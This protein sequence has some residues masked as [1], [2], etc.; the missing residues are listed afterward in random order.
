MS[1][2]TSP[3]LSPRPSYSCD[4]LYKLSQKS[5][6]PN[7]AANKE[8]SKMLTNAVDLF[9]KLAQEPEE[10]PEEPKETPRTTLP[11]IFNKFSSTAPRQSSPRPNEKN[12]IQKIITSSS[13]CS[14]L[15][16]LS[17]RFMPISREASK[18]N[19][20]GWLPRLE[21][22]PV[23]L[24]NEE[25]VMLATVVD[26]MTML[27]QPDKEEAKEPTLLPLD[28]VNTASS[29]QQQQPPPPVVA[30]PP[31]TDEKQQV[32]SCLSSI[33]IGFYWYISMYKSTFPLLYANLA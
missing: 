12:A 29:I 10:K 16:K 9:T 14:D 11:D 5:P 2:L 24:A 30:T 27:G 22:E 1:A 26:L 20:C 31:T 8:Q 17:P 19:T 15:N 25:Q 23:G 21:D 33:S 13:S 3:R 18:N 4:D 28:H 6:R 7:D 32:I